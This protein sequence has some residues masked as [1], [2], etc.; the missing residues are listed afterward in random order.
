M[1][2]IK[3]ISGIRGTIGGKPGEGL[4]PLD[5]VRFTSAYGTWLKQV[6]DS[7]KPVVVTG[8]D[9]RPSGRMVHDLVNSTLAGMGIDVISIG[10]AST[11]TVEIAV[12][13]EDAEG[14]IIIT[15]SHNPVNWNALKLLNSK[16][17]FLSAGE[18]QKIV[19]LADREDFEYSS[20]GNIGTVRD[21]A[22]YDQKHIDMIMNLDLVDAKAI[23]GA[24]FK[25]AVDC[26]NSVGGKVLPELLE[27]LGVREVLGINMEPDG[28]FSHNP[29]PVPEHLGEIAKVVKD[30]G[31]DVGFVVDPDV[32]R[33][34]IISED[35]SFFN[36]EYTLVACADYVL[37]EYPGNTV[38]NMSSTRA[39]RDITNNHGGKWYHSP[40]GEVNVV[41]VMKEVN[42]VIGGEG[43]GGVIYPAIHYGRDALVG[44]ALFLTLL[45][46]RK[47]SCSALRKTYPDYVISKNRVELNEGEDPGIILKAIEE[48]LGDEVTDRSDGILAEN[49]RGWVQVR[50]SNTESI[51]RI[52]SEGKS[53][54][55]AN[56][57]AGKI[58]K[59][60]KMAES[61]QK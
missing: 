52:Y 48:S 20:V 26:V 49:D 60:V 50:K 34:A 6:S 58:I 51:I 22:G 19:E 5:V 13:C 14:G 4:S 12:T 55:E 42:A 21:L 11:P 7:A 25:V 44:I 17:E 36:E 8:R 37:S 46:K 38:S 32:D 1:T 41:N 43:N 15:A 39:L 23:A 35:G 24:G 54:A 45:A 9:A 53:E 59:I 28:N 16:G 3:S 40:V 30:S 47:L 2:L 57:L 29:E 33:L 27:R 61:R 31:A 56:L 10:M 18:G